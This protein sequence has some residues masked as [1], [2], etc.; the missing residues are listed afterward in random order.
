MELSTIRKILS[1]FKLITMFKVGL[2][3]YFALA[4][5][6]IYMEQEKVKSKGH[7]CRLPEDEHL[8][9]LG[10]LYGGE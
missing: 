3:L 2:L 1:V 7:T 10:R 4:K 8:H 9:S 6:E 5:Q